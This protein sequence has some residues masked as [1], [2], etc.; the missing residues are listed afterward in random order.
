[1]HCEEIAGG[2]AGSGLPRLASGLYGTGFVRHPDR[3]RLL[4]RR[5]KDLAIAGIAGVGIP[6]DGFDNLLDHFVGDNHLQFG[7]LYILNCTFRNGI[8]GTD[9]LCPAKTANIG[10]GNARQPRNHLESFH[11]P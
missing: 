2:D 7:F 5:H 11:H 4:D 10:D 8:H 9:G 6:L 3:N 1:L